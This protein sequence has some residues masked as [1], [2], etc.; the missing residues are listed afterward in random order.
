MTV[1]TRLYGLI[2]T[3]KWPLASL[4]ILVLILRLRVLRVLRVRHPAEWHALGEPTM[5]WNNSPR[6]SRG[7]YKFLTDGG[8][9]NTGDRGFATLGALYVWGLRAVIALVILMILVGLGIRIVG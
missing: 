4:I 2:E 6:L 9:H 5:I 7:V 1:F 8:A 3:M